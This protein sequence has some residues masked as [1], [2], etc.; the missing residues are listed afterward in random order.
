MKKAGIMGMKPLG[1][2]AIIPGQNM[3]HLD[4]LLKI[5]ADIASG[6][7]SGDI[8]ALTRREVAEP[9]RTIAE[10]MG[11]MMV[12]VEAREY[13]L[14]T[15]IEQLKEVN[16]QVRRNTIATVTAMAKA[17]AARDAY[18]EGHAERVGRLAGL[19]A[20]ELGWN[21][22][23]TQLVELAGLLHD[24]GKIG[25][26][27]YLF[28]PHEGENP[29]DMVKE[30]TRHPTTGAEIL[31]DLDFLGSALSF[32]R[33]HHERPDGRGYPDR[34]K[35]AEIPLGAKII[36]VADAFDAI[37]TDRPYQKGRS[38]QE[39][40]AIL[41][42]GAGSKWDSGCVAALERTLPK[43]PAPA[44]TA[45]RAPGNRLRYL[46]DPRQ[47][48]ILLA[49]GPPG[50][51]RMRWLRAG[52]DFA[53]YKRL[54]IDRVVFF[55]APDSA[56][57]GMDPQEVKELA[58]LFHRQLV[59]SLKKS[60]PI[61]SA[62]GPDVARLRFAITD[63]R[64][65]RPVLSDILPAEAIG[66][67]GSGAPEDRLNLWSGSGATA[68]EL[69]VIDSA[70]NEVI[71]AGKDDKATGLKETFTKW[72]YAQDAFKFWAERIRLFL[73]QAHGLK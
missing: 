26:P 14:E 43:I 18:T 41:K 45:H 68:A 50:G 71:A 8:M 27:D 56:Y 52:V 69:L 37:T 35:D 16:R 13:Q 34:L 59:G 31:K 30:I 24:I 20:A 72:G 6:R 70:T 32:I 10:A 4:H 2:A 40:L 61:A 54:M 21:E 67:V 11:L 15:L 36:A 19:V 53:K 49:P 1:G 39:A 28:L 3:N 47:P 9:V 17:L 65:N 58:D 7:Y 46:W 33:F 57:K 60:Y 38:F 22:G 29:P 44:V 25:F 63:L 66:S 42:Q 51:A 73:D 12:K 62:P 48:E 23:E 55:F 5:V 64:E